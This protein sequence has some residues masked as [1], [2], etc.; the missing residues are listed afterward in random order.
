M[1]QNAQQRSPGR[2]EEMVKS[3]VFNHLK[4][5]S[6]ILAE[7]FGTMFHCMQNTL[8]LQ[9]VINHYDSTAKPKQISGCRR[10]SADVKTKAASILTKTFIA[11]SQNK[12]IGRGSLRTGKQ[13]IQSED[14]VIKD[15][16]KKPEE[17]DQNV[18]FGDNA[19]Q[20]QRESGI[21]RR[22]AE[23]LKRTGGKRTMKNYTLVENQ[24]I[25]EILVIPRPSKEKLSQILMVGQNYAETVILSK[26]L[27]KSLNGT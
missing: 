5:V 12:K 21:V 1:D 18:N 17:Y 9:D 24:V 27:N 8:P 3:L 11:E 15:A 6:P 25:I 20:L 16:L 4:K 23:L 2:C 19:K 22:G 7:E 14:K 10:V 26:Q 13:F